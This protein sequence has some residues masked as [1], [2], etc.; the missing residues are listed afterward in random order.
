MTDANE[1]WNK[2]WGQE[3]EAETRTYRARALD[4]E[5]ELEEARASAD[6]IYR[7]LLD[8]HNWV[9][10][11]GPG[12]DGYRGLGAKVAAAERAR[13]EARAE[14]KRLRDAAESMIRVW[15]NPDA[16]GDDRDAAI[17]YLRDAQTAGSPGED[18]D[19]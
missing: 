17:D 18:G 10:S 3:R 6:K 5:R 19:T 8:Y 12:L 15:G 2:S 1:Q 9:M 13:N 16:T 7:Q 11:N 4:A 14:V